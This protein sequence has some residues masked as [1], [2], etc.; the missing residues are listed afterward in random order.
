MNPLC[1]YCCAALS[2]A[3]TGLFF[4]LITLA[5]FAGAHRLAAQGTAFAYQGRLTS[6]SSSANGNFD[7]TFTIQSAVTGSSQVGSPV[8]TNNVPIANGFFTVTLDFGSGI[9]TGAARWLEI[10]VRTN[11]R[12]S[13]TTLSPRERITPVPYAITASNLTGA[14]PTA[15]LSG[16]LASAQLAGTYSSALTLNNAGNTFSGNG[17]GLTGLNAA[18]LISG[19]IPDGRLSANVPLLNR[20]QTFSGANFFTAGALATAPAES[21][22]FRVSGSRAGNFAAQLAYIENT[23]SGNSGP[24]L[25]LYSVGN[26]TDGTLNVGNAGTG[27]II[28]FGSASGEVASMDTSGNF[29]FGTTVRQMLNLWGTVYG[30]GV[31]NNTFYTRSDGDFA[32]FNKGV[33]ADAPFSAGAGGTVLMKLDASGNLQPKGA[34]QAVG[35][36]VIENRTSDPASPATGQ[37]WLRTD[38][39]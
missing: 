15:Q 7:L 4:A 23:N 32:W 38:L 5:L 30:V 2:R 13:F 14:L 33:H 36:L 8:S 22:A 28:A 35:G 34:I 31:Q 25:R 9:F 1:R 21:E 3:K 20:V 12:A 16:A 6:D 29:S 39:P 17:S 18:Q 37:I 26:S 24:A 10:G 27:K 11:G 19:T